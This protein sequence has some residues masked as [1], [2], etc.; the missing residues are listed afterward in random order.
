MEAAAEMEVTS[1]SL[2]NRM[3]G[4]LVPGMGSTLGRK[5]DPSVSS[6]C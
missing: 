3:R 6:K 5:K 4:S 2:R 1:I